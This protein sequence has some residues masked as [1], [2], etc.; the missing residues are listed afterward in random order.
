MIYKVI[1]QFVKYQHCYLNA[2]FSMSHTYTLR[3]H[4]NIIYCTVNIFLNFD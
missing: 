1:F 4:E 3:P 2:S